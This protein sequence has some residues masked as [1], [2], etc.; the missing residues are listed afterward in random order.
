MKKLLVVLVIIG[1]I[2]GIGAVCFFNIKINRIKVEGSSMYTD[3]EV[4]QAQ[5]KDKFS[6]NTL[7]LFLKNKIK[8]TEEMPFASKVK[9][10]FNNIHS[11]TFIIYEKDVSACIYSM[12]QY[13]YMDN[14]GIVIECLPNTKEN[15]TVITGVD[16]NSFTVGEEPDVS[17]KSILKRLINLTTLIRY[18][19]IDV[20]QLKT[21]QNEIIMQTENVKVIFGNKD[22]YDDEMAALSYVLDKINKKK[23]KGTIDM[24]DFVSG[25]KI[26]L[27]PD[28]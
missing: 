10:K 23:L 14:N 9:L 21:K 16:V 22:H 6:Y 3:N 4:I 5:M 20:K 13:A 25:D 17:D 1:C 11:I 18:Y 12:N 19:E 15:V 8:G 28:D 7:Y 24:K 27:Q 26:I 2:L